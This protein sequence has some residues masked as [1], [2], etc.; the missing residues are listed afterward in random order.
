MS[1]FSSSYPWSSFSVGTCMAGISWV[2]TLGTWFY[3]MQ[4]STSLYLSCWWLDSESF[5]YKLHRL[6]YA[7]VL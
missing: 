5:I 2:M 1:S 6:V 3:L 7:I 4:N